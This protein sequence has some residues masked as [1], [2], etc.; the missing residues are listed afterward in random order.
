M[1]DGKQL[2][3]YKKGPAIAGGSQQAGEDISSFA[4]AGARA[5][6]IGVVLVVLQTWI[7]PYI[8]HYLDG[9]HLTYDHLPKGPIVVLFVLILVV[10]FLLL[11]NR[12]SK[13]VKAG[14]MIA[15]NGVMIFSQVMYFLLT[16]AALEEAEVLGGVLV[17]NGLLLVAVNG[18]LLCLS[19]KDMSV[20]MVGGSLFNIALVVMI[21]RGVV[22]RLS[23]ADAVPMDLYDYVYVAFQFSMLAGVNLLIWSKPL[24]K[25]ELLLVYCMLLVGAMLPNMG[26]YGYLI[27]VTSGHRYY[28]TPESGWKAAFYDHVPDWVSPKDPEGVGTKDADKPIRWLYEGVPKGRSIPWGAWLRPLFY[29]SVLATLLYLTM[30]C[31][32]VLLRKQWIDRERLPFPLAQVPIAMAEG[33]ESG[34]L[35]TP[36]F[37][38]RLMWLGFAIP[39]LIHSYISLHDVEPSVPIDGVVGKL[40][41]GGWGGG[42]D[43]DFLTEPPWSWLK[44]MWVMT[45][46]SVIG[47]TYLLSLEVSFSLWFFYLI[48][49]FQTVIAVMMGYGQSQW[50]FMGGEGFKSFYPGQGVGALFAMVLVGFYM[51]RGHIRDVIKRAVG[52]AS[53]EEVDDSNEPMSYRFTVIG[54]F[55]GIVG[56]IM[57]CV[58]AGMSVPFA[59]AMIVIFII[60]VVGLTRLVVEGGL[61][62]VQSWGSPLKLISGAVGTK[63]IGAANLTTASFVHGIFNM[64]LR[65]VLMPSIMNSFKIAGEGRIKRR[66]VG[67]AIVTAVLVSLIFGPIA[68]LKISYE[69]GGGRLNSWFYIQYPPSPFNSATA[70]IKKNRREAMLGATSA[71]DAAEE[72][73]ADARAETEPKATGGV[74]LAACEK[75]IAEARSAVT[76]YRAVLDIRVAV[77]ATD[78]TLVSYMLQSAG[79][80]A[81]RNSVDDLKTAADKALEGVATDP[82][83]AFDAGAISGTIKGLV[84]V[85]GGEESDFDPQKSREELDMLR[86]HLA[87]YEKETGLTKTKERTEALRVL[88]VP[89]LEAQAKRPP[90]WEWRKTDWGRC[91]WIAIG[92]IVMTGF[93]FLRQRI[94]W[95]PHPIGYVCF[96]NVHAM[97]KLWFSIF[98]GWLLKLLIIKYGGFR[99]YYKMRDFFIGLIVGEMTAGGFWILVKFIL[100]IQGG[101]K[102]DIN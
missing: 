97:M 32:S 76:E 52:L 81:V 26:L 102:I 56:S 94:F 89:L 46:P 53:K 64:D 66:Y 63:V 6:F 20:K 83:G 12:L 15:V 22:T 37:R 25:A 77:A 9:T 41:Y 96:A 11:L 8:E 29:W 40:R 57:W 88:A 91:V 84:E 27:P 93:L 78:T 80:E 98:I 75:A 1:T 86:S 30:L 51:A 79:I 101:W 5:F 48:S 70:D 34:K 43:S 90:K 4:K 59:I 99:I 87:R 36:F 58:M 100:G 28:E 3:E 10:N 73:I 62:Y 65:C 13:T 33:A 42:F 95:W 72:A 45:Y 39:F 50:D 38:S 2:L 23:A 61:N 82:G 60:V 67:L 69:V 74:D 14:V 47:L 31:L 71:A 21:G 85:V 68:F 19:W 54:L 44:P 92:A 16:W 17:F 35:L 55:V 18:L 49:K 7:T 24:D